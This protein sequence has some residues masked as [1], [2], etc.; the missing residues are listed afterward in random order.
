MLEK[1]N[2]SLLTCVED[3]I[4]LVAR[5]AASKGLKLA[6]TYDSQMPLTTLVTS[7]ACAR[8]WSIYWE[9]RSNSLNKAV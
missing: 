6:C 2:F 1:Q 7:P 9:M 3:A 4:D 5:A 8:S